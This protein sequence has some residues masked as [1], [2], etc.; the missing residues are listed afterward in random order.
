MGLFD[1]RVTYNPRLKIIILYHFN[2]KK[3][4]IEKAQMRIKKKKKAKIFLALVQA[5]SVYVKPGGS[6]TKPQ[7]INYPPPGGIFS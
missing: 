3:M 2:K 5:S 1:S 7:P 4:C 6:A